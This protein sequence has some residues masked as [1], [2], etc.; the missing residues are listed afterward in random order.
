MGIHFKDTGC[1]KKKGFAILVIVAP[2]IIFKL[3]PILLDINVPY[4]RV[5]LSYCGGFCNEQF[6]F[7]GYFSI[8]GFRFFA[9]IMDF[10]QMMKF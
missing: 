9:K 3:T 6:N 1:P 7:Y 4:N 5:I 8:G 2:N 10:C